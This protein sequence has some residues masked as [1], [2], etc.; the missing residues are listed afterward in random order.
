MQKLFSFLLVRFSVILYSSI[1][2]QED[3]ESQATTRKA[4]KHQKTKQNEIRS[5]GREVYQVMDNVS[6]SEVT[7]FVIVSR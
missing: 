3:T 6:S 1:D 5:T 2:R 7:Y 4:R